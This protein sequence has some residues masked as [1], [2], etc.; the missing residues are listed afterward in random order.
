MDDSETDVE[1]LVIELE[2]EAVPQAREYHYIL[3]IPGLRGA[4]EGSWE[5][6]EIPDGLVK[7]TAKKR[8]GQVSHGD[9]RGTDSCKLISDERKEHLESNFFQAMQE[10]VYRDFGGVETLPS[11]LVLIRAGPLLMKWVVE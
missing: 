2:S 7:K 11:I 3:G 1:L 8:L 5:R 4:P 10:L 6:R 9:L